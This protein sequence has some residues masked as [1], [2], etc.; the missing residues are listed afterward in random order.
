MPSFRDPVILL[1]E[2][3][4]VILTSALGNVPITWSDPEARIAPVI[5]ALLHGSDEELRASAERFLQ[6]TGEDHLREAAYESVLRYRDEAPAATAR[7]VPATF[8]SRDQNARVEQAFFARDWDAME[9]AL[10]LP[11]TPRLRVLVKRLLEA[12][13]LSEGLAS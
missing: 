9:D 12:K 11:V 2:I 7:L 5:D 13:R 3:R 8:L 10:R 1:E 6:T 4:R